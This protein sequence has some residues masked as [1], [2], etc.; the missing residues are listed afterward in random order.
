MSWPSAGSS[1]LFAFPRSFFSG[2]V[3]SFNFFSTK[4]CSFTSLLCCICVYIFIFSAALCFFSFSFVHVGFWISFFSELCVSFT[5][6]WFLMFCRA[7]ATNSFMCVRVDFLRCYLLIDPHSIFLPHSSIA[8]CRI[9]QIF[10]FSPFNS[11]PSAFPLSCFLIK[12]PLDWSDDNLV[13]FRLMLM[14]LLWCGKG[15]WKWEEKRNKN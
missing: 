5:L 10:L 11:F 15:P 14:L 4:N 13:D 6:R 9:Y 12:F 2:L 8:F 7:R 1:L 3:K